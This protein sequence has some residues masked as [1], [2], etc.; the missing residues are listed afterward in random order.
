MSPI[1]KASPG[2]RALVI[3]D[4][5]TLTHGGMA[6]GAGVVAADRYGAA[7]LVDPRP[8]AVGSIQ[9]TFEKFPHLGKLLP[10]MGYSDTAA[11]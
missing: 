8:Y 2:K 10:A 9:K 11:A 6:Y 3:E 7:Q 5:P 4:G 1:P